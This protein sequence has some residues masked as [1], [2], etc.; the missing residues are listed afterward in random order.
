MSGRR[1]HL[2][3]I[4]L[5]IFVVLNYAAGKLITFEFEF[6]EIQGACYIRA[7]FS[8]KFDRE[9]AFKFLDEIN[10]YEDK[11]SGH[12]NLVNFNGIG[13]LA[14]RFKDLKL[15]AERYRQKDYRTGKI[16]FVTNDLGKFYLSKLFIDLANGFRKGRKK[17]FKSEDEAILW[18]TP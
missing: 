11:F 8:G 3:E 5:S 9:L 14:I 16:A 6:S 17:A 15:M 4:D 13:N 10:R 2:D 18:L 12:L 7:I 1:R